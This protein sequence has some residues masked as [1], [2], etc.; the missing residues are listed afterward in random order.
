NKVENGGELGGEDGGDSGETVVSSMVI[1]GEDGGETMI[2]N[3]LG[4]RIRCIVSGEAPLSPKVEEFLRVTSWAFVVHGNGK[5]YTLSGSSNNVWDQECFLS[6][7][8]DRTVMLWDQRDDKFAY[9]G[10]VMLGINDYNAIL[11]DFMKFMRN[12]A[13]LLI[14]HVIL[15]LILTTMQHGE[16]TMIELDETMKE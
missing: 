5:C 6:G 7:S 3:K 16:F 14:F 1:G 9:G 11:D 2:K 13:I 8:L 15:V 12:L 10:S 4:G